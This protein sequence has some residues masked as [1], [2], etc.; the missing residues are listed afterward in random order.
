MDTVAFKL[1]VKPHLEAAIE[2][3]GGLDRIRKLYSA[4]PG[5]IDFIAGW[6]ARAL[7]DDEGTP[8]CY[9]FEEHEPRLTLEEIRRIYDLV[10]LAI[11]TES[12]TS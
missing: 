6:T 11:D 5:I 8:S 10:R 7:W 9:R 12:T 1:A 2:A 3:N 4:M